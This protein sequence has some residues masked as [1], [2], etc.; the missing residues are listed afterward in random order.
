MILIIQ[1][2]SMILVRSGLVD[3]SNSSGRAWRSGSYASSYRSRELYVVDSIMRSFL[4]YFHDTAVTPSQVFTG[5]NSHYIG[6]S[7]RCLST[8]SEG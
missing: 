2:L 4:F 7:L 8:A 3:F 1:N 5:G 6:F